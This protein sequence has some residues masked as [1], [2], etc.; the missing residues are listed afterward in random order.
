VG[1]RLET[2]VGIF[3]LSGRSLPD[4]QL[5]QLEL[6]LAASSVYWDLW[7]VGA[8]HVHPEYLEKYHQRID[9]EAA[10]VM[11]YLASH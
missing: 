11:R 9:R 1:V 8:T 5:N 7:V 2:E 4:E 10:L 6:F 3:D